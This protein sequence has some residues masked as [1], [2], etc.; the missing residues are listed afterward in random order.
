MRE[1]GVKQNRLAIICISLNKKVP[2][3]LTLFFKAL[4]LVVQHSEVALGTDLTLKW[5]D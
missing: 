3:I 4:R 1:L 5:T 2:T